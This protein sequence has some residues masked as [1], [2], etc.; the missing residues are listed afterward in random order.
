MAG[1]LAPYESPLALKVARDLDAEIE[2]LL[3]EAAA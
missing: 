1:F 3:R 2:N